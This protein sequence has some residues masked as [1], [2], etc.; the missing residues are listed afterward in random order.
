MSNEI[1][2]LTGNT[3]R[4]VGHDDDW[5]FPV[6]TERRALQLI[7]RS[8]LTTRMTYVGFPWATLFDCIDNKASSAERL[9]HALHE[10]RK[11][12][13]PGDINITVCQHVRLLQHERLL[14][15]TG[16]SHVFW[17][18]ASRDGASPY[19]EIRPF[20]LFPVHVPPPKSEEERQHLFSFVGAEAKPGYLTSS[21]NW[22]LEALGGDPRG[23]VSGRKQW[24]YDR[25]VYDHQIWQKTKAD[26]PLVDAGAEQEFRRSLEQSIFVLC[27]S[28]TG[29]NSIRLWE[30]IGA[31]AIPVL[32]AETWIAPGDDCLWQAAVL[33]CPET[34]EAIAA[35]PDRL[36]VVAADNRELARR[37]QA[38]RQLWMMYG[39]DSFVTD[40]RAFVVEREAKDA[41]IRFHRARAHLGPTIAGLVTAVK[42]DDPP[43][44]AACLAVLGH[45]TMQTL[46]QGDSAGALAGLADVIERAGSRLGQYHP[47]TAAFDKARAWRQINGAPSIRQRA[48]LRVHILQSARDCV[49]FRSEIRDFLPSDLAFV[50]DPYAANVLIAATESALLNETAQLSLLIGERG[51]PNAIVL[52]E[53]LHRIA[54]SAPGVCFEPTAEEPLRTGLAASLA[55]IAP[56][57]ED[58]RHLPVGVVACSDRLVRCL[59]LFARNCQSDPQDLVQRWR[60]APMAFLQRLRSE[61]AGSGHTLNLT[62]VVASLKMHQCPSDLAKQ[63]ARLQTADQ[64]TRTVLAGP[65]VH[66][67]WLSRIDRQVRIMSC[68]EVIDQRAIAPNDLF[69][70]F[71]AEAIPLCW[72]AAEHR[73][74]R[75]IAAPAIMNIES[76][77]S[78]SAK[79]DIENSLENAEKVDAYIESQH[80]LLYAFSNIDAVIVERIR[81]AQ[82]LSEA[83]TKVCNSFNHD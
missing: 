72:L 83:L 82:I 78:K 4:I 42:V 24:H 11:A 54:S 62:D 38:L 15:E 10:S 56:A 18:H 58:F 55:D 53:R 81:I 68:M 46:T 17:S 9:L 37:R 63:R 61:G 43:Q 32:L 73:L 49:L 14:A 79:S 64:T 50:R 26:L 16:I 28:G 51:Q 22:I 34:P 1:S 13:R 80:K 20:P 35:L 6:V 74:F 31:G 8:N 41:A 7:Q 77:F 3:L 67:S 59:T 30:A 47:T 25:I 65:D 75:I 39:P 45:A 33:R 36:G 40:I 21:R 48:R 19:F 44:E 2:A 29:P 23:F 27:P 12:I 66:L 5:Q 57:I 52:G 76:P 60:T 69:D 71:A 70:A